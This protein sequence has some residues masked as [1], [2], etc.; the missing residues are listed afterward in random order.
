MSNRGYYEYLQKKYLLD[1]TEYDVSCNKC[2]AKYG[3]DS[4]ITHVSA[5]EPAK[6][7]KVCVLKSPKST[8]H[9]MYVQDAHGALRRSH[10]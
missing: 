9:A 2:Y 5:P 4:T 7:Q 10:D 1:A 6:K 3:R 8:Q